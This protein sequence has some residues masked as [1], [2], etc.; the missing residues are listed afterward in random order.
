MKRLRKTLENTPN[1]LF[2]RGNLPHRGSLRQT[3]FVAWNHLDSCIR[4][5]L[6]ERF[7]KTYRHPRAQLATGHSSCVL[8]VEKPR[9]PGPSSARRRPTG[10]SSCVLEVEKPCP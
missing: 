1:D 2:S 5:S 9:A 7:H 3:A 8:E 6:C 10:H 4:G